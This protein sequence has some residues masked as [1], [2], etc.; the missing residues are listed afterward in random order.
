[1]AA[2]FSFDEGAGCPS[3][4]ITCDGKMVNAA[5]PVAVV[6]RKSRREFAGCS[7][8]ILYNYSSQI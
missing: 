5:T 8:A 1:M 6:L 7:F 4:A 2:I 3:P